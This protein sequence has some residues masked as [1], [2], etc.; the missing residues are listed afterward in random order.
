LIKL[1]FK[2]VD[3]YKM[4]KK[5]KLVGIFFFIKNNKNKLKVKKEKNCKKL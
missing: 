2:V 4:T 1:A 5:D 3:K